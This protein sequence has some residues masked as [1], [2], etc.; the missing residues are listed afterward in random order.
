MGETNLWG[1]VVKEREPII[2]NNYPE[3]S[4]MKKISPAGHVSI[5]N[6]LSD[7]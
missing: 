3:D 6:Y 5:R 2:S 4:P 7:R 1:M